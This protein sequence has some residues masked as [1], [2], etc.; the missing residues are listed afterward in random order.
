MSRKTTIDGVV[1]EEI[2]GGNYVIHPEDGSFKDDFDKEFYIRVV[3]EADGSWST[4]LQY[5]DEYVPE[6]LP[7]YVKVVKKRFKG[8]GKTER[9]V[10]PQC[11]EDMKVSLEYKRGESPERYGVHCRACKIEIWD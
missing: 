1:Y 10:C 7:D 2:T 9:P 5:I 11:G 3:A 4:G 8:R 6:K